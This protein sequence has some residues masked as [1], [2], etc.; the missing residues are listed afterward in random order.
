MPFSLATVRQPR[1]TTAAKTAIRKGQP[2]R[3]RLGPR[4]PTYHLEN[5]VDGAKCHGALTIVKY[6][7]IEVFAAAEIAFRYKNPMFLY[8]DRQEHTH[9]SV[10]IFPEQTDHRHLGAIVE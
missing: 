2:C 10:D 6:A 5:A 3:Y 7:K 1:T 9:S 4:H 8:A